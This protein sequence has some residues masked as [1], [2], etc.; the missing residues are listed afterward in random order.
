VLVNV[1]PPLSNGLVIRRDRD[2][3]PARADLPLTNM[4]V[5]APRFRVLLEMS[6]PTIRKAISGPI[7][8]L[9]E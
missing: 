9:G 4:K 7:T 1:A 8:H 6:E 3:P 5:P 2:H